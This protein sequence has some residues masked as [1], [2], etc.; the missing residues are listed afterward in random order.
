MRDR[1][2]RTGSP[3]G[4]AAFLTRGGGAFKPPPLDVT[5][6]ERVVLGRVDIAALAHDA[7][8]VELVREDGA[9]P[10][11]IYRGALWGAPGIGTP[12]DARI[13]YEYVTTVPVLRRGYPTIPAAVRSLMRAA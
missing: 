8:W 6:T 7:V 10:P 12:V 4:A 5:S 2:P 3:S 1:R 9:S 11:P 13:A